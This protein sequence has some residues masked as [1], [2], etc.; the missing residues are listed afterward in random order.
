MQLNTMAV[1]IKVL[2]F[3]H[4]DVADRSD[5]FRHWA[6]F[7]NFA[8]FTVEEGELGEEEIV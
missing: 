6:G 7:D 5:G 8:V 4:I 2:G 1:P 3:Y